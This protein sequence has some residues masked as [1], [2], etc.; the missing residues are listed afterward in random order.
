MKYFK[1]IP[2]ELDAR[3]LSHQDIREDPRTGR[4]GGE[5]ELA[6]WQRSSFWRSGG[7]GEWFNGSTSEMTRH[8]G[9]NGRN[10]HEGK[11]GSGERAAQP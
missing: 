9:E 8:L 4:G 10:G 11:W 2:R 6:G 3:A 1:T 5:K 7:E